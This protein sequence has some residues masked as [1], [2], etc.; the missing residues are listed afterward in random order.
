MGQL[1]GGFNNYG[2]VGL[3]EDG[4]AECVAL[5]PKSGAIVQ[6]RRI[7]QQKWPQC[8][9]STAKCRP[10]TSGS[11]Q[12][13]NGGWSAPEHGGRDSGDIALKEN[14][15]QPRAAAKSVIANVGNGAGNDNAG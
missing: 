4:K 3:P 9:R 10:P 7:R 12:I 2:E 13:I 14:V 11:R 15:R 8:G 1:G 6:N 5:N